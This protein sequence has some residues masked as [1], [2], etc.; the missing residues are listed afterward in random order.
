[1]WFQKEEAEISRQGMLQ[2]A[3]RFAD[4]A[5]TR[6]CAHP[7]RVLLLPPDITRA[8]SGTGWI[9]EELYRLFADTSEVHVIPTL[10][11]HVP[12]TPKQN[13]RMFGAIPPNK[14]GVHDWRR[15]VRTIGEVPK[16]LV[17]RESGGK[18]DWPIPISLNT[19]LLDGGWDLI[20]NIGH[21]APHEVLGF[22][23]HNKN[24]FIGLGGKPTICASHMMAACCGIEN[25]LGR[26]V[27]PLRSCYNYAE[28]KLRDR[29]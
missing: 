27:T 16:S 15:G 22:A 26:R 18:A 29:G 21:V 2:L 13:R 1:M 14:I 4:E 24:Y 20:L 12:H 6:I 10:G 28:E 5:R 23:N 9:A 8:H 3:R 25:N 17:E 7:R 11:Q 19:S